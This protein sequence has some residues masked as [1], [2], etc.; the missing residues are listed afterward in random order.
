[1]E[2]SSV[3]YLEMLTADQLADQLV[4][5][6]VTDRAGGTDDWKVQQMVDLTDLMACCLAVWMAGSLAAS[7]GRCLEYDLVD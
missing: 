1:M 5:L 3:Q 4:A 6:R 7:T 2:K